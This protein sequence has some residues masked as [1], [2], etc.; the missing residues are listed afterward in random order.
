MSL[1]DRKKQEQIIKEMEKIFKAFELM[2]DEKMF[3][4]NSE[5]Q[6]IKRG[7]EKQKMSDLMNNSMNGG[8]VKSILRKI[9]GGDKDEEMAE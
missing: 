4:L 9:N 6:R 2:P 7:S 5:V 1:V 3:I 8:I